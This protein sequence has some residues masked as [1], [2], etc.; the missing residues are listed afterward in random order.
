MQA[1][2][3]LQKQ[4]TQQNNNKDKDKTNNDLICT[5][6]IRK[7]KIEVIVLFKESYMHMVSHRN[8]LLTKKE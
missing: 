6:S 1:H 8:G 4:Q 7:E 2:K 3:K 5:K